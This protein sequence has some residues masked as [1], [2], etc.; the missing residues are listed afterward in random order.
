MSDN[1]QHIDPDDDEYLDAPKA[2][3]DHVKK[4]QERLTTVT[5]E[6]D[7]FKG[8]AT[9]AA[10][11]DVLKEYKNPDRVR[12]DLLSDSIDPLDSKAVEK[13]LTDNG[14]DYAKGEAAPSTESQS[15]VTDDEAQAHQRMADG[16]SVRSPAAMSK[17]EA[18]LA[19]MPADASGEDL[20]ALY[21]KH[22]V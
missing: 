22:G 1:I 10:L 9:S 3:R 11:G 20:I 16:A 12:K 14:S 13:W 7:T 19:E 2:L 4:L 17:I 21:K 6:R 18:A 5:S 15:S 8:R